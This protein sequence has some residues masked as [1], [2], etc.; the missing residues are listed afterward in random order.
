MRGDLELCRSFEFHGST[1]GDGRTTLA[2]SLT[3]LETGK[4]YWINYFYDMD[5]VGDGA[6][7]GI[8]ALSKVW[9]IGCS[10]TG[11]KNGLLTQGGAWVN[12]TECTFTDNEVGL[13]YNS[14]GQSAT[15]DRYFDNT[16]TDN[17]TAVLL[18][19]VPTDLTL[20]FDGTTFSG[21]GTDIDNQCGHPIDTSNAIFE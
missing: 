19:N 7:T 11:Y 1:D 20:Y 12:V 14:T 9:A 3:M 5:F 10:F 13:F 8:T 15:D 4:Y 6:N 17:G 2:G 16:F 18:M 21:N